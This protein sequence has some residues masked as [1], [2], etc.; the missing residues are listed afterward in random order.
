MCVLSISIVKFNFYLCIFLLCFS[1]SNLK[2]TFPPH[3]ITFSFCL[4][5]HWNSVG[6][7]V[8]QYLSETIMGCLVPFS[9]ITTCYTWVICRLQSAMFHRRAQG[10]RL[11]LMIICTFALFWLPYH[12][13]NIIQ[14]ISLNF[15][16]EQKEFDPLYMG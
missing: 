9:L 12:I 2:K 13:V 4:P 14:V 3:N 8:F 6:H 10:S 16:L 11:I 7:Q 15:L 5:Y 1:G